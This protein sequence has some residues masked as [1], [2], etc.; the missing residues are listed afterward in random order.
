MIEEAVAVTATEALEIG[1]IDFIA[2]DTEDLLEYWM[3]VKWMCAAKPA[4]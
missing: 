4:H 3:A 1:L 2:D